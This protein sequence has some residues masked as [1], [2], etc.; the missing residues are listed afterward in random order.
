MQGIES[1]PNPWAPGGVM[2][3]ASWLDPCKWSFSM[4]FLAWKP[5]RGFLMPKM[6]RN[7]RETKRCLWSYGV[8]CQDGGSVLPEILVLDFSLTDAGLEKGV[9]LL[10]SFLKKTSVLLIQP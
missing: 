8:Q 5:G 10:S 9:S 3:N 6:S 7:T 1:G 4:F 2:R